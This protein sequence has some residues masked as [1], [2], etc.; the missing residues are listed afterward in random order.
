MGKE[1]WSVH[2]L[3]TDDLFAAP[4]KGEAEERVEAYNAWI[5]RTPMVR[6]TGLKAELLAWPY[7]EAEHRESLKQWQLLFNEGA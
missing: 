2:F 5:D 3:G 1:L 6:Y 7:T 4:S